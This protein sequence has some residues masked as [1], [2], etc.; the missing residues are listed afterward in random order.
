MPTLT[1]NQHGNSAIQFSFK[2]G[3]GMNVILLSCGHSSF[4]ICP[5]YVRD[6]PE[7]FAAY[8]ESLAPGFD[9]NEH[10]TDAQLGAVI[11]EVASRPKPVSFIVGLDAAREEEA[12]SAAPEAKR[13]PFRK[14][15]N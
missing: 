9:R 12:S 7:L 14:D 4:F 13:A 11:V 2:N 5:I 15:L 1:E 6:T 8:L 3:W 10:V